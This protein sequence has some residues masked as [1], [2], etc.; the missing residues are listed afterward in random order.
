MA[1]E[2]GSQRNGLRRS[3]LVNC[4]VA[5]EDVNSQLFLSCN[6]I[7]NQLTVDSKECGVQREVPDRGARRSTGIGAYFQD[8]V[9]ET[10]R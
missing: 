9:V 10:K 8:Y 5:K 7:I 1:N 2:C 3:Y 6:K 4:C